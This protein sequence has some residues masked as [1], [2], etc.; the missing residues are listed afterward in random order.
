MSR[1]LD[2]RERTVLRRAIYA[3][4]TILFLG[5]I[6]VFALH[7]AWGMYEKSEDASGRAQKAEV[8]LAKQKDR[9]SELKVD[10]A[11]LSTERGV[12]EEIR[13]RFMVAKN[14]E[15]IMIISSGDEEKAHT[16]TVV[17]DDRTTLQK[18]LAAVG[19]SGQ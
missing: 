7:G 6:A 19:F 1:I 11:R 9:E 8:E 17:E 13:S 4:P 5:I 16:V 12:E 3:K 10:I 18:V 2:Y 15:H 14:G